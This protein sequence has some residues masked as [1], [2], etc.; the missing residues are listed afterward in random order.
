MWRSTRNTYRLFSL[1]LLFFVTIHEVK[2]PSGDLVTTQR[3]KSHIRCNLSSGV[4]C[5]QSLLFFEIVAEWAIL[6]SQAASGGAATR[7]ERG[8]K[9]EK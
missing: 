2:F 9:P 1:R 6:I 8:R 7:E 5:K 4:E 3:L